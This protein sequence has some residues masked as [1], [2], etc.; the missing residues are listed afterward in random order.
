M[1][2]DAA[3]LQNGSP[4]G[5]ALVDASS[6]VIQ[7]LSYEGAFAATDGPASGLT[8]VDIGVS[9]D[10]TGAVGDSLQLA[11]TGTS[12]EDFS[13]SA[14]A[15]NTFGAFNTGQFFGSGPVTT[16][17]SGT[18]AAAPTWSPSASFRC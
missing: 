2:F 7:F 13:W 14:E 12:Y 15:P 3:G 10:G 11:G 17:P 1:Y 18:G 16:N 5:V 4:D 9:E 8:S 6:A